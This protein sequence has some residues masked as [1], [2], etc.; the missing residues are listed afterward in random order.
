MII[1]IEFFMSLSQILGQKLS[2]LICSN[3][4]KNF[5]LIVKN[6]KS[7]CH[8]RSPRTCVYF[9][10]VTSNN[11]CCKQMRKTKNLRVFSTPPNIKEKFVI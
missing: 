11:V 7:F 6:D 4:T 9:N 5:L 3:S 2:G 8:D 1:Q 10:C